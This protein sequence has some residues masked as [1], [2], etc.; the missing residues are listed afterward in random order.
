L[1]YLGWILLLVVL[2]AGIILYNT[3]YLALQNR[4]EQQVRETEMWMSK[5]EQAKHQSELNQTRQ[6]MAP[7][8]SLLLADVFPGVDSFNLT[9]LGQDTLAA[10]AT[11]L[12][13]TK[14][15]ITVTVYTDDNDVSLATKLKYANAWALAAA[16]ASV[17]T[18]Y[19][20]SKGIPAERMLLQAFGGER[21]QKAT[22]PDL[23][24]LSSRRLEI[25]VKATP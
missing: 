17:V 22:L 13:P 6:Q 16:K 24:P 2:G 11:Q 15:S 9:R 10:L 20:Q 18:R 21:E 5:T 7:D 8:V 23:R 1:K 19:L 3:K 12:R 25:R 4:L 14:G